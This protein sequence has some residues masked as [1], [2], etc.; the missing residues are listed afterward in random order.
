VTPEPRVGTRDE[1]LRARVDL[2]EA[3]KDL[4][5]RRDELGRR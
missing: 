4:T 5:R 2:L 1:W 3:E